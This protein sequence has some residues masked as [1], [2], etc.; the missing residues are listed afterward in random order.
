M[1]LRAADVKTAQ[2]GLTSNNGSP[3]PTDNSQRGWVSTWRVYW[4]RPAHQGI[5]HVDDWAETYASPA[6]SK[7]WLASKKASY[8][9]YWQSVSTGG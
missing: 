9:S 6:D 2:A 1:V 5:T 3:D 7:A 8:P 4:G